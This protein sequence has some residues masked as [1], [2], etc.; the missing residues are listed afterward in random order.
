MRLPSPSMLVSVAALVIATGGTSYAVATI[1]S[2]DIRDGSI[3][4]RDIKDDRLKT[5]DIADGGLFA[6]DFAAG[7]LPRG[8]RGDI[9]PRGP[10]G[11]EGAPG[12]GRWVLINA[13]GQIEAQSGGF[14][15]VAAYPVLPNTA[16]APGD[17]T[18]RANGNVY[19]DAGEDLTDNAIVATIAL[20]NRVDQNGDTI[21]GGRAPGADANPEF[22]GEISVS[23]CNVPNLTAIST[24]CAP[25]GA[26]NPAAF[27]VSPR[28]SDGSVTTDNTRKRFYVIIS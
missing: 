19:I 21:T 1:G 9:G 6:R 10:A 22:S 17:N 25:T 12:T 15:L 24:N 2:D 28:N 16:P 4:P 5:N 27:V 18:L 14:T 7:Q 11:P 3:L 26:Q 23:Q 8:P 13:A 20:Q